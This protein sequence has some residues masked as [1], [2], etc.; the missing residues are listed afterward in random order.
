MTL[1]SPLA[2]GK[3]FTVE[4]GTMSVSMPLRIGSAAG[5]AAIL[6]IAVVL[7]MVVG[8]NETRAD[9][10]P[11]SVDEAAKAGEYVK[12]LAG[13]SFQDREA[14]QKSLRG[15]GKTAI[16]A[17]ELGLK[18]DSPEVV[19]RCEKLLQLIYK[20]GL[21][22][23]LT[24]KF[25]LEGPAW[26]RFKSIACDSLASRKLFAELIP[27]DA[28]SKR[29]DV[30]AGDPRKMI[31]TYRTESERVHFNWNKVL[32]A[33]KWRFADEVRN[34]KFRQLSKEAVS[35]EDILYS[36]F[37][38]TSPIPAGAAD[39]DEIAILSQVHFY[40]MAR[41][42][43]S[44]PFQK[45]FVAW[46]RQRTNPNILRR[47]VQTALFANVSE[48]VPFAREL[49]ANPKLPPDTLG[50]AILVVGNHGELQD[51]SLLAKYRDDARAYHEDSPGKAGTLSIQ[52]REYAA[53]M[54]LLLRKE[55]FAIHGFE[56]SEMIAWWAG[57]KVLP[58]KSTDYLKPAMRDTILQNAW[59]W[60]DDQPKPDAKPAKS[61]K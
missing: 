13:D 37:L 42:P 1:A 59:K 58:F 6:A 55:D 39:A 28:R 26:K 18:S 52:L 9:E 4:D 21:E 3:P 31:V 23:F 41:G 48:A 12:R 38:G 50:E 11:K 53:A 32:K 24:N 43:G 60:L 16:P 49:L 40:E 35:R 61:P 19:Q 27:D 46:I 2:P 14:A 51:V 20:D 10:K 25:E 30:I 15:M 5:T 57:E 54:S 47:G 8:V 56:L 45:L 7:S 34:E 36:L 33:N 44:V 22:A 29:L 17:I